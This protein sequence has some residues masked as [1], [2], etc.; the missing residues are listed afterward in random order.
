MM[1]A[2]ENQETHQ[3]QGGWKKSAAVVALVHNPVVRGGIDLIRTALYF[4]SKIFRRP[5]L[6]EFTCGGKNYEYF[7]STLNFTYRNERTVEVPI[8]WEACKTVPPDQVLEVGDVLTQY[9]HVPHDVVDK[10]D[11]IPR[12]INA[13]V[14]TF[15]TPKRYK[16]IVSIS[17]IEHVG[18]D[19][20]EE[21]DAEKIPRSIENLKR[22]LAPGGRLVITM[23]LGCNDFLDELHEKHGLPIEGVFLKRVSLWNKWKEV[24]YGEVRGARY[25]HPFPAANALF[26]GMYQKPE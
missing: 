9:Y 1:D 16:L 12:I 13:D 17:T 24:P 21:R 22:L 7:Y 20:P 14:E 5:F 2:M 6:R 15:D 23:P 4:L 10:Y 3:V 26:I 8:A 18:W 19:A 11:V 25:D